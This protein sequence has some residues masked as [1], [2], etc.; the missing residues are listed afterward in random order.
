MKRLL[1]FLC[2]ASLLSLSVDAHRKIKCRGSLLQYRVRTLTE[3]FTIFQG[4]NHLFIKILGEG[5]FKIQILN[6]EG[7]EVY[8]NDLTN[9]QGLKH[10]LE[11][12]TLEW[13]RGHYEI[14]VID[15]D[16][17]KDAIGVFSIL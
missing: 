8:T 7:V 9:Y 14:I 12:S 3:P 4:E 11:V 2:F 15:Q 1:L 6:K 16:N 5:H 17:D 10:E 13:G